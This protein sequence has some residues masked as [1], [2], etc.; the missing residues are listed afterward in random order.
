MKKVFCL[1]IQWY[2]KL[3]KSLLLFVFNKSANLTTTEVCE[4]KKNQRNYDKDKFKALDA[5]YFFKCKGRI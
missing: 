4:I 1:A 5:T 3:F 2:L